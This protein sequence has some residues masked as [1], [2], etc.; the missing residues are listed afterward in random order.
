M[1]QKNKENFLKNL[2]GATAGAEI[3][4]AALIFFLQKTSFIV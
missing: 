3:L 2:A 4:G 1:S